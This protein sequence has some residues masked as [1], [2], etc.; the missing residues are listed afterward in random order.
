[1]TTLSNRLTE[2]MKERQIS[3]E[4]LAE[5]SGVSQATICKLRTGKSFSS[6]KISEIAIA[7][8]VNTNWLSLGNGNKY[9]GK[10]NEAINQQNFI[11]R[12]RLISD[13]E[14]QSL[15]P[16]VRALIEIILNKSTSG[17][18]TFNRIKL[19]L[20]IVDELANDVNPR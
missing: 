10:I 16:Q 18:L 14:W 8:G 12:P 5:K 6:R 20:N 15:P 4:H 9:P 19:L 1:M 7:L 13:E 3:Q 11:I 2:V 17:S